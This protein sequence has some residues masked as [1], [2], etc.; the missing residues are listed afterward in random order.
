MSNTTSSTTSTTSSST[1][2]GP[3][4]LLLQKFMNDVIAAGSASFL[5]SPFVCSVDK[6]IISNASGRQK[7]NPCLKENLSLLFRKPQKF[8]ALREFHLIWGVYF[9]T[10]LAANLTDTACRSESL[11]NMNPIMP[12]FL[13]TSSVNMGTCILK[14]REFTKM[15]QKQA[16]VITQAAIIGGTTVKGTTVNATAVASNVA[17]TGAINVA[18]KQLPVMTYVLF[19]IRDSLTILASFS[20]VPY[21]GDWIYRGSLG[22]QH[23]DGKHHASNSANKPYQGG[24]PYSYQ[25]EQEGRL[26]KTRATQIA[27]ISCPMA[28]QFVST[29]LHLYALDLFNNPQNKNVQRLSFIQKEYFKTVAARCGRILPAFGFGGVG[30]TFFRGKLN[31]E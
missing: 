5:L 3:G 13:A 21:V 7:L 2:T 30:N 27:Q 14:D 8:F 20:I 28:I 22:G 4:P 9:S 26:T 18:K 15:F 25:N 6:C 31:G 29:P 23:A 11:L 1:P 17:K 24:R 19:A 10:Y 16:Q 12:V